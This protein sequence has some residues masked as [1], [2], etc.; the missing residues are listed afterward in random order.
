M[1]KLFFII[2]LIL[3]SQT[4]Y[5]KNVSPLDFGLKKAT[6]GE[7]RFMALYKAHSYAIN[8]G[9]GVDYKG[10]DRIDVTIPKDSPPIPLCK[11]NDFRGVIITV[12]SPY[13]NY[14][15]FY[16][17]SEAKRIAIN[18]EDLDKDDFRKYPSLK[19]G[20]CLLLYEDANPWVKERQG[21]NYGAVRRDIRALK[22]GVAINKA[23][24]EYS[25]KPFTNPQISYIESDD[26]LKIIKNL[27]IFRS[28]LSNNIVYCFSII[29]QNN[30]E[31]NN[32]KIHTPDNSKMFGDAVFSIKN[33]TNVFFKE[34][35]ID[36]TYS[37][38]NKYGYGISMDNVW[39]SSFYKLTADAKWGIFGCYNI[40]K[41]TIDHCNINRFDIHCYGKDVYLKQTTLKD[42]YSQFSSVYGLIQYEDCTFYNYIPC[43]IESSFNAY[44]PFQLVIKNCIMHM[45]SDDKRNYLIDMGW[46]DS[47]RNERF[48]LSEKSWPNVIIEGLDIF[49]PKEEKVF[50]LF[51]IHNNY[52]QETPIEYI[53]R[54]QIDSI[55]FINNVDFE[56]CN[57]NIWTSSELD[58]S[59]KQNDSSKAIVGDSGVISGT[60][61]NANSGFQ[62]LVSSFKV[63][64]ESLFK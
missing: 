31:F 48:E 64:L 32:I 33:S 18:E 22:G 63:L 43:L 59:I 4:G 23:V 54:I 51:Y 38:E 17:K 56:L 1:R 13:R 40:N 52:I 61:K 27:T 25:N 26:Y 7:E 34:V 44:V 20:T 49:L 60:R 21:F 36:G 2:L 8:N 29:G 41:C 10:I 53:K 6:N 50:Y 42:N 46:P 3:S 12:D 37:Q 5:T 14:S 47:Q 9:M 30:I 58:I 35:L 19:K 11:Y 45:T 28:S 24:S 16:M 39:N 55:N 15:L 57:K 62:E